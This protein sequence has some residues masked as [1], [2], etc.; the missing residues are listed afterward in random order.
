MCIWPQQVCARGTSTVQPSRSS[1]PTVAL[2]TSGNNPST[3]Q[4]TNKATRTLDP[5]GVAG[6]SASSWW[7]ARRYQTSPDRQSQVIGPAGSSSPVAGV[8]STRMLPSS[9]AVRS[10]PSGPATQVGPCQVSHP[11][12]W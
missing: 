2:P 6:P 12:R 9:S 10:G 11:S 7:T 3:R 5:P 1:S 4:V 8:R